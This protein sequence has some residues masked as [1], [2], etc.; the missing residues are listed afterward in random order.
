MQS[1][2]GNVVKAAVSEHVRQTGSSF[3]PGIPVA[4]GLGAN[5]GKPVQAIRDACALLSRG[6][7]LYPKMSPLYQTAP[8]ACEPGTPPFLNAVVVGRWG[9][10]ATSLLRLCQKIERRL[11]RPRQHSSRV[12]RVIDVDVLLFGRDVVDEE[13]LVVPHP[14]LRDRLFV[15]APLRDVAP[16]WRVPPDDVRVADLCQR[17]LSATPNPRAQIQRLPVRL[18]IDARG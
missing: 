6:G 10:E 15:L 1:I 8:V 9:G 2:P 18:D 3:Q 13:R 14:Q 11:G 12:A 17:L 16:G 4:V 7:V 5:M